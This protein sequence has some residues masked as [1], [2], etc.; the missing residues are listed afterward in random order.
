MTRKALPAPSL[1]LDGLVAALKDADAPMR[2][3]DVDISV[4]IP[5]API[6]TLQEM[7]APHLF[8]VGE[9]AK[10]FERR[11]PD[12]PKS[13]SATV[14]LLSL[15]HVAPVTLGGQPVGPLYVQIAKSNRRMLMHIL[16]LYNQAFPEAANLSPSESEADA[17]NA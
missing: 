7:D 17:K 6:L 1:S 3:V 11:N 2:T 8:Q 16:G 10:I 4:F 15:A 13:L 14:A 12:W 9:D 5:G